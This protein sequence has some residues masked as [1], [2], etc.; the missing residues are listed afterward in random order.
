MSSR[1]LSVSAGAEMPPPLQV[2][3]LAIRELAARDHLRVDA[4]ARDLGD[5]ELDQAV[6]EQQDVAGLHVLG[7]IQ[8]GAADDL[9]VAGVGVVRR[10]ERECLAVLEVHLL[11]SEALD[12]DLGAAEIGEDAD[13]AAGA[14]R[15]FVHQ[16]DAPAVLLVFAVREVDARHVEADAD[17]FGQ[18]F[19]RIGG[20]AEGR[21]DLRAR[22]HLAFLH[23]RAFCHVFCGLGA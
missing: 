7:Q 5:L 14:A 21:D 10:V 22:V 11:V 2:H 18:D 19:D 1:S 8:V 17:H 15:R 12:A 9:V 23:G 16:V 13:V 20:R 4:R 3:A 6:V